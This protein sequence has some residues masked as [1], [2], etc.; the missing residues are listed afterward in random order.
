VKTDSRTI[1]I[2]ADDAEK[3]IGL[4]RAGMNRA[5]RRAYLSNRMFPHGTF[6]RYRRVNAMMLVS[7]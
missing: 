1:R 2:T 7:K 5:K 4:L 6:G 3:R